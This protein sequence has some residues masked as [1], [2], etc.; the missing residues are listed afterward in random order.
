MQELFQ[1]GKAYWLWL[2]YWKL[3]PRGWPLNVHGFLCLLA[4][5]LHSN[6]TSENKKRSWS[7]PWLHLPREPT[8]LQPF[9]SW[10]FGL[11]GIL[12]SPSLQEG[13]PYL[14]SVHA[15]PS[16]CIPAVREH[17]LT[18]K[19]PPKMPTLK[20][21]PTTH[22]LHWIP[23]NSQ[24]CWPSTWPLCSHLLCSSLQF[25]SVQSLS[26]VRLFATPWIASRQAS[27]SIF[28][29]RSSLTLTSIESVMHP[30]SSP[31]PP[32]PNPS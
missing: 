4:A 25:S 15:W 9:C 28:N 31:S 5:Y 22:S 32:A 6:P 29:S 18:Q 3:R 12:H 21:E 27:L 2:W 1:S 14:V 8:F 23:A 10:S 11:R 20:W 16:Q 13:S 7:P 30:L 17:V 26:R 19:Q 24:H